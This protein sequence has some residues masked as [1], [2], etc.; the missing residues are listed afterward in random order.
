MFS[1]QDAALA[2]MWHLGADKPVHSCATNSLQLRNVPAD[3][4]RDTSQQQVSE[5]YLSAFGNYEP[6]ISNHS[7][8]TDCI[9]ARLVP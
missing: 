3:E 2:N 1:R 4:F 5:I 6:L 9:P 7:Q 8:M